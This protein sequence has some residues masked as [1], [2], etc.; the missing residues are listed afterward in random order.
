MK[1][2]RITVIGAITR[3]TLIFPDRKKKESFGGILYNISA[4]SAL[5]GDLME[6][7]PVCNLGYDVYNQVAGILQQYD[8]VK[9]NGIRKVKKKNNHVFLLIDRKNEREEIL[10]N[11]VPVL[12][13]SQIKPFLKSDAVLVNFISGFDIT[14][15]TLK[16][17]R[18]A[19][20]ALMFLDVHSFTLG[21]RKDGKR[22]L[23]TP[24]RWKE[25]LKQADIV[26]C[27]LPEL[28]VLTGSKLTS[29]DDIGSFG[30]H[31]LDLGPKILL[32]TLG[33]EGSIA[34]FKKEGKIKLIKQAGI[35]VRGFK[36]ATG[37]G[38]V[39]SAGFLSCYLRTKSLNQALEFAD[40]VAAKKCRVSGVKEV[41]GLLRKYSSQLF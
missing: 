16:R 22:F 40:Q 35:N 12:S 30:G 19:T 38:D 5:G 6:I 8:N 14:L 20:N 37:C 25:Y 21:I 29:T 26:Q 36:D 39:F 23:R 34:I 31:I 18:R 33:K 15:E 41:A 24:K 28:S 2:S 10:K 9:P 27:N 13:F 4:L 32:V 1:K 17:I 7:Y 3:D 11:R